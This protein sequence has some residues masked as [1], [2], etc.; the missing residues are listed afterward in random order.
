MIAGIFRLF[1]VLSV[2]VFNAN[3]IAAQGVVNDSF[4]VSLIA[5]VEGNYSGDLLFNASSGDGVSSVWFGY[6]APRDDVTWLPATKRTDGYWTYSFHT[7]DV[8]D[9]QYSVSVNGTDGN[10]N[11]SVL[12]DAVGVVVD[13]TLPDLSLVAPVEGNYTGNVLFNAS[14]NDSGT[15]L[16]SVRFGYENSG[17][18][19]E[20]FD[21][22]EGGN[23]SW[24]ATLDTADVTDGVYSLSV[25]GTDYAGNER[26][27]LNAVEVVVDNDGPSIEL[28]HPMEGDNLS[29]ELLFNAYVTDSGT[30]VERALFL[31]KA[32][33][34]SFTVISITEEHDGY[35]TASLDTTELPDG[36]YELGVLAYDFLNHQ[37]TAFVSSVLVD[38]TAP[39]VSLVTPLND[40]FSG[41]L[42]FSA[43]ST[44]DLSG[45]SLVEFGYARQGGD[46]NWFPGRETQ[47]GVWN[48]SLNTKKI[49]NGVYNVSVRSTDSA[50]SRKVIPDVLEITVSNKQARS[51]SSGGGGGGGGSRRIITPVAVN[52]S[53]QSRVWDRLAAGST[54]SFTV[55]RSGIPV[56]LVQ[57]TVTESI[58]NAELTVA[59]QDEKPSQLPGSYDGPVYR[60]VT[61]V[62]STI[63]DSSV[64]SVSIGFR[65]NRSFVSE[66]EASPDDVVLFLH[67]GSQWNELVTRS[68]GSDAGTYYYEAESSALSAHAIALG[69]ASEFV[70]GPYRVAVPVTVVNVSEVNETSA[71]DSSQPDVPEPAGQADVPVQ[72]GSS[73]VPGIGNLIYVT[74]GA[75]A[76]IMFAAAI[77][78]IYVTRRN[79][80]PVDQTANPDTPAENF[81]NV[82]DDV[83]FDSFEDPYD[84][85][86][87]PDNVPDERKLRTPPDLS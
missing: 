4:D 47:P 53:S 23:G 71:V 55:T 28:V 15:G 52:D 76:V 45:V 79:E 32:Q 31:Y 26:V 40:T 42:G 16:E 57:F 60:Y 10:G 78:I 38:N 72:S 56:S 70:A 20:W 74:I 65:V 8:D 85:D 50:G 25:S 13:N 73:G 19:V 48:G 68:T 59:A 37:S 87:T 80:K 43:R 3:V 14:V 5:P 67:D 17:G 82:P 34:G 83:T 49:Q 36:I 44:D 63:G 77:V 62:S 75:I 61:M 21:G 18:G 54:T 64:S 51:R 39:E 30:G 6:A 86:R 24:T 1:L 46:V 27:L 66:N 84:L 22:T 58:N 81:E 69:K 7:P 41:T 2:F 35:W 12:L 9:G 29:G 33:G 11:Y